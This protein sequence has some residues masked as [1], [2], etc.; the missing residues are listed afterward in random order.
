MW[1]ALKVEST[2]D[3]STEET[4]EILTKLAKSKVTLV[5]LHIDLVGS[6]RLSSTLPADESSMSECTPS[7]PISKGRDCRRDR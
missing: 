5:I 3:L 6:T 2:F 4:Q 1:K 7:R